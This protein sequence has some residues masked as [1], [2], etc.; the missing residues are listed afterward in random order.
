MMAAGMAVSIF[1]AFVGQT[2]IQRMQE[3]QRV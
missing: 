3:M 2:A 1:L